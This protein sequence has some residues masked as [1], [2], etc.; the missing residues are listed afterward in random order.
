[1]FCPQCGSN[2]PDATRF[3]PK[4]GF[5][6]SMRNSAPLAQPIQQMYDVQ[7]QASPYQINQNTS[8]VYSAPQMIQNGSALN[9]VNPTN[10]YNQTYAYAA[11]APVASAIRPHSA[12]ASLAGVTIMSV[13]RALIAIALGVAL[14]MPWLDAVGIRKIFNEV[15]KSDEAAQIVKT[16]GISTK[17][18]TDF[19]YPLYNMEELVQMVSSVEKIANNVKSVV[20]KDTKSNSGNRAKTVSVSDPESSTSYTHAFKIITMGITGLWGFGIAALVIGILRT[21]ISKKSGLMRFAFIYC[22]VLAIAWIVGI[23]FIDSQ[24]IAK[25]STYTDPLKELGVSVPKTYLQVTTASYVAAG[26]AA[27]G[28]VATLIKRKA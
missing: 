18:K 22:L 12:K 15:N 21:L 2:L 13:L 14:S 27:V 3:C 5:D 25:L 28:F 7:G 20:S 26:L 4:C 10:T 8:N 17:S 9:T 11:S 16:S 19:K 24:I 6:M 23:G 1:M